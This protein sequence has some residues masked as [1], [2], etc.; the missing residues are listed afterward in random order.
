MTG[1]SWGDVMRRRVGLMGLLLVMALGPG[2][3]AQSP[4][5]GSSPTATAEGHTYL[6]AQDGSGDFATI[7][8]AVA[9][10]SDGDR[11]L[12]RPG[13]YVESVV[14]DK[15]VSIEGDGDRAAIVVDGR[16][17]P[18][19]HVLADGASLRGLTL[20]GGRPCPRGTRWSQPRTTGSTPA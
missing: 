18:A 6:V 15:A 13:R 10:A 7:G 8:A 17:L 19:F 14:L 11:V 3:V 1:Q 4:S 16:D 9:A 2:A 20:T 5:P 12:V